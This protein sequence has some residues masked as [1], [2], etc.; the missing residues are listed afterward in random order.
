MRPEHIAHLISPM[1]GRPMRLK[2]AFSEE[3]NQIKD[4]E[5]VDESGTHIVKISNFIPRFVEGMAYTDSFGEQWNRYRS[6][7]IDSENSLGLTAD[8]FY[9][10]THWK[11]RELAGLRILEVGCGAG[12][13]TQTMLNAGA[14]V[15][16]VDGSSAVD[17]CWVTNGPHEN[18]C[19]LQADLYQ[20]PFISGFFDRVFCYGVLQHT[21]DPKA[22]FLSLVRLLRPGGMISIDCYIKGP[23]FTRWTSKVP[24]ATDY[25]PHPT[26]SAVQLY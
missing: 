18:L 4:G 9:K 16:A 25:N 14:I 19:L 8:R 21:P 7:Q 13:F 6:V 26:P 2:S 22:A 11:R 5:L 17:A 10:W 1:T 12:R 3:H 20:I 23:L 24:L 15:Y